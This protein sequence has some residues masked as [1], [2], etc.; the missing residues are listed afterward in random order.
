[1]SPT[2][3]LS[4]LPLSHAQIPGAYWRYRPEFVTELSSLLQG[5]RV[6]EIFAGNGFLAAH[7]NAHGVAVTAT[8]EFSSHDGHFL[9]LYHPVQELHAVQ[10]V[11]AF[12]DTH[13]VLLIC[14]PTVTPVVLRAVMEWGSNKD[15]LF[16]GEVTDYSK[17]H[18]GGCATDEFFEA[19]Q[20]THELSEYR[21]N[22]LEKA[23]VCRLE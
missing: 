16:I 6:L 17:N 5:R 3:K 18:L 14:W 15:I 20:V 21:G 4:Y 8:S 19:I 13:D 2:A 12:R 22:M 11:R 1:M 10:A 23:M 7:L 9:G